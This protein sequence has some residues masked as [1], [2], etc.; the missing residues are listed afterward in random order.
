[1]G[2]CYI[3]G[4][5]FSKAV[6]NLPVMKDLAKTFW[7]IRNQENQLGHNNRVAWGD[8]IREYLL[9]LET[10]FFVKPCINTKNG[11]IYKE[12]NFHENLEAL[13][14]FIDLNISGEIKARVTDK[15]G[16]TSSY[17]KRSL[18]WNFTDLDE[19]RTC[20][21]TYI[22]LALIKPKTKND[23]LEPFL[24]RIE[25][26]DKIITFN[27]DLIIE[28]ALFDIGIWKPKDGYG[29]D[30]ED[31][32]SITETHDIESRVQIYKLHGSLN[33]K[34]DSQPNKSLKLRFFYDDNEPIFPDYLQYGS[35]YPQFQGKHLG[36]WILPSF[37]KQFT[38][39]KLIGVWEKAFTA[40][41]DSDV[42]V[43][44]GYSLPKED[45]AACL[46]LGTTGIS[47]K[48]LIIVDP[49]VDKLKEKYQI[50]TSNKHIKKYYSIEDFLYYA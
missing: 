1:M 20:I 44:V 38:I 8:K 16:N 45:S 14:S 30:F 7:D 11:D 24:G 28:K 34:L 17:S 9:Y 19:L 50:I 22:Y 3:L 42:I 18:F 39:P 43:I 48:R 4:A 47:K 15:N 2:K 37:I 49:N 10:E 40:I 26:D 31:F 5:G 23:A 25:N 32:P 41:N 33:W 29:I 27:Y 12:C 21:Q 6:S 35:N 36:L 13:I 46:L